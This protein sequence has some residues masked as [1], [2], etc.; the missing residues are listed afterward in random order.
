MTDDIS[1]LSIRFFQD[2]G[3]VVSVRLI[4]DHECKHVGYGFVEFDSSYEAEKV[5]LVVLMMLSIL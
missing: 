3:S 5:R 2:V 4:V 1:I